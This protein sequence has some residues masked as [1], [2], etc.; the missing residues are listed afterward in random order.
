MISCT[1]CDIVYVYD[2]VY[3]IHNIMNDI[4]FAISYMISF[5]T[6]SYFRSCLEGCTQSEEGLLSLVLLCT[7]VSRF[8]Q[9]FSEPISLICDAKCALKTRATPP[10]RHQDQQYESVQGQVCAL[11]TSSTQ[12]KKKLPV[13]RPMLVKATPVFTTFQGVC[14]VAGTCKNPTSSPLGTP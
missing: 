14:S 2:I 10:P 6:Q 8:W 3:G 11:T 5:T 9:F 7:C 13:E 1:V 12:F 4:Q